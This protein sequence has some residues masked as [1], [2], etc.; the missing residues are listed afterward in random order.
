MER[1]LITGGGGFI[2]SRTAVRLAA[3][4]HE[5]CILDALEPPV[6]RD[7]VWPAHLPAVDRIVGDVRDRSVLRQ[8]LA[9][10]T[11]VLHLAAHQ[12]YML[13]FSRFASVNT[14]GTSLLYEI[15]VERA[16]NIRKVVVGSSQAIYGEG[17]YRCQEH[18]SFSPDGRSEDD[19]AHGRWD[20]ECPR[21]SSVG[22]PIPAGEAATH[23][24]SAYGA[25]K[26]TQETMAFTLGRRYGVPTT[27]L[28][29]SITQGPGQSPFNA[30]SGV[31]R[32]FVQ[33]ALAR[34]PI[35]LFEDGQQ[36]RDYVHIDDV[37]EA[38]VLAL[39]NDRTDDEALNVGGTNVCTVAEYAQLVLEMLGGGPDP[40][41]PGVYRVGDS[42]HITSSSDRIRA[43]G[44]TPSR[45]LRDIVAEYT[46]WVVDTGPSS[47]S[48]ESAMRAME[49]ARV[50]RVAKDPSPTSAT[51]RWPRSHS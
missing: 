9:G 31:C 37:V 38:N 10:V 51:G 43:L 40:V 28:R 50:L 3:L 41:V 42:R 18:G 22:V 17:L 14:V 12:D 2:G 35:V 34:K 21:C 5:V 7:R 44:W 11:R 24:V 6:H 8:A 39:W 26:L 36:L 20:V 49:R 13:E 4:G 45:T 1:I 27:C 47:D 32:V 15:I 25:S 23:P 46:E 29:Y 19:L 33:Q 30:Y 16:M 48:V